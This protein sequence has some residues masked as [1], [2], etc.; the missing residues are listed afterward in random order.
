MTGKAVFEAVAILLPVRNEQERIFK[1]AWLPSHRWECGTR[2][3][4]TEQTSASPV[5]TKLQSARENSSVDY[6]YKIQH[7]RNFLFIP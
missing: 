7:G 5:D 3:V 6:V 4:K 1:K 2:P